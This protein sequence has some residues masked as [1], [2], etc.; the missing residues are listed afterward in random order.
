MTSMD[1]LVGRLL[2]GKWLLTVTGGFCLVVI[3]CVDCVMALRGLTPFVDPSTLLTIVT[4]I[5][6]SYFGRPAD[7]Q[8][9]GAVPPDADIASRR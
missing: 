9:P 3:T 1:Q 2:S 4:G 6:M 8:V 7:P 5:V